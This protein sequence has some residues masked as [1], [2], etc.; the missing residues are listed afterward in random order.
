MLLDAIRQDRKISWRLLETMTGSAFLIY[1]ITGFDPLLKKLKLSTM[2]HSKNNLLSVLKQAAPGQGINPML[3]Q[4]AVP[5][6]GMR[7]SVFGQTY[8]EI[9]AI[10]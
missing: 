8:R 4:Q 2:P 5:G 7:R 9:S 6:K 1:G 10:Q 3:T